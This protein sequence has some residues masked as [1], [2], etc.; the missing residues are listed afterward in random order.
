[1]PS[2]SCEQQQLALAL[3]ATHQSQLQSIAQFAMP[4][5]LSPLPASSMAGFMPAPPIDMGKLSDVFASAASMP[6]ASA[7]MSLATDIAEMG[8]QYGGIAQ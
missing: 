2:N 7:V 1:L 8:T 6:P 3:A 5:N 4:M